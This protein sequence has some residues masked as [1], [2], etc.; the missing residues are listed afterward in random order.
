MPPL[1]SPS[2]TGNITLFEYEDTDGLTEREIKLLSRFSKIHGIEILR[3]ILRQ[4]KTSFQARQYVGILRLG[5]RTLQILP[6]VYRSQDRE[7]GEREAARNLLMMLDYAGHLGIRETHLAGL[8]KS[9]DWFEVLIHFF[10]LNLKRQWIKGPSRSYEPIDAS[11]SVLKGKWRFSAQIRRPEQKHQFA[12]TYDEF[13]QDN[14]LNRVF[15][16]VVEG[17]LQLTRDHQNHQMLSELRY[18]MDGILLLPVV[19]S[20]MAQNI[21]L[22][23]MNQQYEPLLNLARLFLDRI[24]LELSASDQ[25]AFAFV[26]DMNQLFEGFLTGFIQR[27]RRDVL[28]T[29]LQDCQILPQGRQA[30]L[31]LAQTQGRPVFRLKPDLVFRQNH[32]YPLLIDFKYKELKPANHKVG[33]IEADFYQMYA[34]LN[35]FNCPQVTLMYPQTSNF[36]KP[37]RFR[38]SLESGLG[39]ITAVTVNLLK[40]L[41]TKQT[42]Q[43]LITEL[44]QIFEDTDG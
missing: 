24:G 25:T 44:N 3:P 16:Y 41:S 4:G 23:R 42:K 27:H 12:V 6:K 33:I 18:W 1:G 35:R 43:D 26:F 20:Q 22:T 11:L 32:A 13:T 2:T 39:N 30:V 17:L 14:L 29:S 10:A 28:P 21:C 9:K 37:I 8:N 19:T 31:Y 34:Y 38:F 40:D 36:T 5:R 15:R 7:L